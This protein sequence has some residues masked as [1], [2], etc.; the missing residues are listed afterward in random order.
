MKRKIIVGFV[1]SAGLL[2]ASAGVASAGEITGN[3]RYRVGEENPLQGRSICA[4]SGLNDEF[5]LGLPGGAEEGR[6]QNWGHVQQFVRGASGGAEKPGKG[7]SP[8][9]FCNPNAPQE[10]S[11]A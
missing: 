2:A 1:A 4:Y 8:G 11:A 5:V 6:T 7:N 9:S 10:D 3:G